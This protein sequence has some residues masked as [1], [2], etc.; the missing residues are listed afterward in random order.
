MA[1]TYNKK[2]F[3]KPLPISQERTCVFV[4]KDAMPL[5][6]ICNPAHLQTS[7]AFLSGLITLVRV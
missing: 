5:I 3:K 2:S 4:E 6:S 1:F 7:L